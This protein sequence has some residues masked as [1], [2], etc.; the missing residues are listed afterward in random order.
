[1][2]YVH[3]V[4]LVRTFDHLLQYGDPVCGVF[5]SVFD[6]LVE[7]RSL[8]ERCGDALQPVRRAV[9]LAI[10]LANLSHPDIYAVE[11]L[12]KLSHDAA[13]AVAQ[14]RAPLVVAR[15]LVAD[16]VRSQAAILGLGLISGLRESRPACRFGTHAS[17]RVHCLRCSGHEQRASCDLAASACRLLSRTK[18]NNTFLSTIDA[19][20]LSEQSSIERSWPSVRCSHC[21]GFFRKFISRVCRCCSRFALCRASR[22][23]ARYDTHRLVL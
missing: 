6:T 8:N 16:A 13:P 14:V 10:A 5:V 7:S 2:A 18:I 17:T 23:S 20:R 1:M 11:S 15:L 22:I 19:V 3:V 21:S 12:S 4:A 9:P